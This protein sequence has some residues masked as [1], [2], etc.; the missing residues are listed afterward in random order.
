MSEPEGHEA[1][2]EAAG[3]VWYGTRSDPMLALQ[4]VLWFS[5]PAGNKGILETEGWGGGAEP[6]SCVT[7]ALRA[8]G[9]VGGEARLSRLRL[10]DD[11]RQCIRH[12][13][14]NVPEARWSLVESTMREVLMGSL[15]GWTGVLAGQTG[16]HAPAY[17]TQIFGV[18]WATAG[19]PPVHVAHHLPPAPGKS[20]RTPAE[21]SA[22]PLTDRRLLM[23][24]ERF[25]G[26]NKNPKDWLT[27]QKTYLDIQQYVKVAPEA[28]EFCGGR[29]YEDKGHYW[30]ANAGHL[31]SKPDLEHE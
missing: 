16:F 23:L 7:S 22:F 4:P 1:K 18:L 17:M 20:G 13:G 2:A 11:E 9:F 24:L 28:C 14:F 27:D 31:E 29:L 12:H 10:L 19:R 15:G 5:D 3:S 21:L 6:E 8:A 30:C 26:A 25:G